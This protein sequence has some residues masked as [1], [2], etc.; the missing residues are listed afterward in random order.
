MDDL[1][2]LRE[3]GRLLDPPEPGPRSEVHHRVMREFAQ[4]KRAWAGSRRR[5]NSRRPPAWALATTAAALAAAFVVA[6]ALDFGGSRGG[7]GSA[8]AAVMLHHAADAASLADE[9]VPRPDQFLFV[10]QEST[11]W[12]G[13]ATEVTTSRSWYSVDERQQSL[14]LTR[15]AE[16]GW[17][18]SVNDAPPPG[19]KLITAQELCSTL[20]ICAEHQ[21]YYQPDLPTSEDGMRQYLLQDHDGTTSESYWIFTAASNLLDSHDVTGPA[22]AALYRLLADLPGVDAAGATTDAAGR[23]AVA[24][25]MDDGTT[26]TQLLFDPNTNGFIGTKVIA[27]QRWTDAPAGTVLTSEA[28]L[29]TAVVD[30]AGELP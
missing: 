12:S 23:P 14:M 3:L 5:A 29:R 8:R 30:H 4:P 24:I 20:G 13:T 21:P 6:P 2:R 18:D 17:E 22:R 27:G 25:S 16:G 19:G 26:V 1:T 11:L 15:N 28:I 10:E 7:G 9:P